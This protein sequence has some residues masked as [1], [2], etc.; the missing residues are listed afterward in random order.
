M[1]Q[2]VQG[3]ESDHLEAVDAGH[4]AVHDA[5]NDGSAKESETPA[6]GKGAGASALHEGVHTRVSTGTDSDGL[7]LIH[8]EA[9]P[10]VDASSAIRAHLESTV[11]VLSQH[12]HE[13]SV[14]LEH[15]QQELESTRA[16]RDAADR[17]R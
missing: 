4:G 13:N 5:G 2:S 7:Y 12:L 10:E 14:T 17:A 6:F 9:E 11:Q 15:C 3:H 1:P 16:A 8:G